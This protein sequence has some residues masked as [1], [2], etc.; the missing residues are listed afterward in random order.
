MKKIVF[1]ILALF[2]A[3]SFSNAQEQEY[4]TIVYFPLTTFECPM[5]FD[6]VATVEYYD[7][8]DE[9]NAAIEATGNHHNV[10]YPNFHSFDKIFIY[11]NCDTAWA[12]VDQHSLSYFS[13]KDLVGFETMPHIRSFAQPYYLPN[14]DSNARIIGVAAKIFGHPPL[15]NHRPFFLLYDH[16]GNVLDQSIILHF[17]YGVGSQD[18]YGTNP[19]PTTLDYYL[20]ENQHYI[21]AFSLAFD[22]NYSEYNS[23]AANI[24]YQF[25]H[26][27]SIK[28][29]DKDAEWWHTCRYEDL[30]C[31]EFLPPY[32]LKYDSTDWV[33]FDTNQYYKFYHKKQIGF[34]PV[35]IIPKRSFDLTD[36]ELAE[37]CNLVPNP[38]TIYSKAI[39]RFK[40]ER[41]EIFDVQGKK[42]DEI[43]VDGYEYYINLQSYKKGTYLVNIITQKGKTTKKLFVQ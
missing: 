34:F 41:L 23:S 5:L 1:L 21:Q 8:L 38:A 17:T 13:S 16:N 30:G 42:I 9:R 20:F 39:S 43:E 2:I 22:K 12:N 40:I 15:N 3:I 14:L 36:F 4:D 24:P 18:P 37:H 32:Y 26:T 35:I 28:G 33:R 25:D 10:Y 6:P 29:G 11:R 19:F 7:R 31:Y 27:M